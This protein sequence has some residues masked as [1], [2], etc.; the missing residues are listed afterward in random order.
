MEVELCG[1]ATLASAFVILN[2]YEPKSDTVVFYTLSGALTV[3]RKENR[4]EMD[5][6]TYEFRKIPVTDAMEK[7]FGVRPL[8]AVLGLDLICV[9]EKEE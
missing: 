4:Y 6:P 5:F 3:R 9:F 2:Y 1:H 8:R 7:A